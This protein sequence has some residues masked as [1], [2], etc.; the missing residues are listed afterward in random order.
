MKLHKK[1]TAVLNMFLLHLNLSYIMGIA[2]C[3]LNL[4][5]NE[6]GLNLLQYV[7]VRFL[8]HIVHFRV[9]VA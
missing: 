8:V 3:E 7:I 9:A 6:W 2:E 5:E 4:I 1:V